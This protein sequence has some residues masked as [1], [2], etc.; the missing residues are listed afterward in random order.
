MNELREVAAPCPADQSRG[1]V[2]WVVHEGN[3]VIDPIS[4]KGSVQ[5]LENSMVGVE[6]EHLLRM[7]GGDL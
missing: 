4:N 7:V 3:D 5:F 2:G 1:R 6:G